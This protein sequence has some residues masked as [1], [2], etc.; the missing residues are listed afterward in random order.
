MEIKFRPL[1]GKLRL[2]EGEEVAASHT[3]AELGLDLCLRPPVK[4]VLC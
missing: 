1:M 4:P 2:R 3:V